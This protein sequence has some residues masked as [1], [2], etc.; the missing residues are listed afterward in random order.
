MAGTG[1]QSGATRALITGVSGFVGRHLVEHLRQ[2]TGWR[3]IGIQGR[4]RGEIPG[5]ETVVCD[6]RDRPHLERVIRYYRPDYV[7]HLAA[8]S[9]VPKALAEPAETLVNNAVA[10]INLLESIRAAELDPVIL[11][12]GSSEV[13]GGP[14]PEAM[15]LDEEQPFRPENPYAVS[16][17][18]QDMLG[19]QYHLA[20]GMRIVR[21]RPFNHFGPGQSDRFVMASFA[22]QVA[23][24]ERGLVPPV[25]LVGNLEAQR[26]FLDVRDVVRAYLLVTQ[27]EFAGEVFNVAS[28]KPRSIRS[29]LD[30]LLSLAHAK[31]EVREDPGRM[32]PSDVPIIAGN[33]T[34]LRQAT[35]WA[36]RIPFEQTVADTL[37]WWR[38]HVSPRS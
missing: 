22:R 35:G 20:Y 31:L 1:R 19:L 32:R 8:Q 11:V 23:E 16:K 12:V 13:Y 4:Q 36:P 14:G 26:D 17:V 2:A 24:A 21:V 37:D 6:L 30:L 9:Y 34:K 15:P 7:F 28:G 10:Q 18:T 29:A 25:I 3:L 27:P 33:A 5:V 38:T